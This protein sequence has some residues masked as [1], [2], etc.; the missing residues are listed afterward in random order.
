MTARMKEAG[1]GYPP[2]MVTEQT[3]GYSS[4]TLASRRKS[5]DLAADVLYLLSFF[6]LSETARL[7]F[8]AV[9][10][11]RLRRAYAGAHS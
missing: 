8:L 7:G 5:L 9:F 3:R 11:R 6:P 10:D 1:G 4:C 2:A